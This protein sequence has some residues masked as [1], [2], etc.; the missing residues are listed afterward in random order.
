[1]RILYLTHSPVIGG[2][3]KGLLQHIRQINK[4][5]FEVVLV[6]SELLAVEART[7]PEI[8]VISMEFYLLHILNP[9][10][11]YKFYLM[12]RNVLRIIK[13]E[14]I[15][16]LHTNSVKANYIGT[17]ASLF[18]NVKLIWWMRDDT[19]NKFIFSLTRF[20][21]YKIVYISEYIQKHFGEYPN[22]TIIYNGTN[23]YTNHITEEEK[24]KLKNG[25]G[26]TN[27]MV[28][29][30][31]ERLV[32]W[33]GIQVLIE[34]LKEIKDQNFIC[35]LIGSG[36]GQ[37]DDNEFDLIRQA[38][39]AGLGAKIKFLGW[40]DN[41]YAYYQIS[42]IFVHPVIEP[43]PFGLVVIEAMSS[44][45]A[46]ISSNIGGPKEVIQI[47]N[48]ILIEPNNPEV[49][50]QSLSMLLTN[51]TV[52]KTIGNNAREYILQTFTQ[53]IETKQI[54]ALYI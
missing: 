52:R 44:G 34:S 16:Y 40:R 51:D 37:R 12:I 27:Q 3:E 45:L 35:L 10:I 21:P 18:T 25:L 39:E 49:L 50:A 13:K 23:I 43:E 15:S 54:E 7:I 17:V 26:I 46:V 38:S 33:K 36:K 4:E 32:V 14:R 2:A 9:L 20:I 8:T 22:A 42:D 29:L 19:M 1:M 24:Q 47:G 5:Q 31:V 48:G 6:C 41:T 30:S 28:I 11:L 53:E